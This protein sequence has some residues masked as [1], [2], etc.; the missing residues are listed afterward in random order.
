MYIWTVVS[1][2][3]LL[4]I[5]YSVTLYKAVIG[6]R[7]IFVICLSTALLVSNVGSIFAALNAHWVNLMITDYQK[8]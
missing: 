1:V 5:L 6:T 2:G 4:V 8:N 7:F 3:S